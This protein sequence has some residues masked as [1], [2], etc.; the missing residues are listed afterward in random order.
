[1][2]F[3]A[4]PERKLDH[5]LYPK[6]RTIAE[7]A[8][9]GCVAA[10]ITSNV[11]AMENVNCKMDEKMLLPFSPEQNILIRTRDSLKPEVHL[12]II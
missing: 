4:L 8:E 12:Q 6:T 7:K 11:L 3:A 2:F 9:I 5:E 10:K 1:L